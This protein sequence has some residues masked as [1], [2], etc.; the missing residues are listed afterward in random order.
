M[1]KAVVATF[2]VMAVGLWAQVAL[3]GFSG[4]DLF[5]PSVGAKPGVAP[6]IWYTTVYV[7]NPNPTAANVTFYLLER[8]ANPSPMSYT[9][10]IQPGDTAK[11]DNAVQTMFGKQTFGAIRLTSN[12]KVIAG[13]RIY[14]QS[15]ALEDSVGQYFAGTP[16]S[17]AIGAG[18]R[19]ELVG[20]YGTLPAGESTFRYNYGFVETT[21]VGTCSV[22][23]TV[24]DQ[25][26]VVRGTKS[27][28]VRQWEQVQKG[29]K[30]EFPTLNMQNGRLTVEV[31]S[32]SGKVIVFGSGVANGSQDP[33]TYE[34]AFR[35]ELLA[36]NASG[37]GGGTI[38]G[39][40]AGA[41]LS[42]GG[43]SGTVTLAIADNGVTTA[44][45]ANGAV[46]AAKVGT[47]GGSAGQ[48]L[49]VTAGGAAWQTPSG[50]GGGG[51]TGVT[52]GTG[53][54]G[55]GTSGTVTVGIANGGVGTTQLASG[56]VTSA[57]LAP[58]LQIASSLI[59]LDAENTGVGN[60]LRGVSAGGHGVGGRTNGSG[61]AGVYGVTDKNSS[62]GVWGKHESTFT[63]VGVF[64]ESSKGDGVLGTS[65][66]GYGVHGTSTSGSGVVGSNVSKGTAGQLGHGDYGV[67]GIKNSGTH[68]GYFIGAVH[69]AGALSK[70][71][72]SFKIDHPLDPTG[73]YLYHSFV[74]SPD[75]MNVYNGNVVTDEE[76]RAVVELPAYFEVLNRDFRYQLTVIGRFAQAI[77][78]QK[79]ERNRFV[80]RTNLAG[81][82]VSW[83]VTGIRKDP[84][85]EHNR[86]QVEEDK[87]AEEHGLY[88]H[89][90]V[91]D[92]P[93][94]LAIDRPMWR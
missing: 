33:A 56:A 75:M 43:T 20:V 57:K 44:K 86:I 35:D 39:V 38:T 1:K 92:Q 77:V 88:L 46:T 85:A 76:G 45:L 74:E 65:S 68:A 24:K 78:E 82:E 29:M 53:L 69:V 41:G 13:S 94:E 93:T 42:G 40:T 84:W 11:Y 73:K 26:G 32:G 72:G 48:V 3:A 17:F 60:A 36:E 81:V 52:A 64:G 21:G 10:T 16:A 91:Y 55:G 63:G 2:M 19:T 70:S 8:Q 49:T 9:D 51:I 15:G 66:T 25:T 4:T 14:S 71:S 50:G 61:T 37:G 58:P 59:P 28:T 27:Y 47:S 23:V 6:A 30:D 54:S 67:F 80:I 5:L 83:Q 12:V 7:H 18:Q 62:Y 89:P 87:P 22:K 31:V 90:E 79:I 34:M